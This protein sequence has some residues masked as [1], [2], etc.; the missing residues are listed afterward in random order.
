[1]AESFSREKLRQTPQKE[2]G[3]ILCGPGWYVHNL[4]S[5][6]N[7]MTTLTHAHTQGFSSQVSLKGRINA[8]GI[9]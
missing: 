3:E 6:I 5:R 2:G 4:M 9:E 1:M 8:S 7:G